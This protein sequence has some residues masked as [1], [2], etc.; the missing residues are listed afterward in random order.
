MKK[1]KLEAV[2]VTSF[3]TTP[4]A[5][6]GRGTV[7]GAVRPT[8]PGTGPLQTCS[9]EACGDTMYF[10]CTLGCSNLTNCADCRVVTAVD[11]VVV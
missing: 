3:A 9:L 4:D 8:P 5:A 7:L 10:D 11:C 6:R 1:L 2:E